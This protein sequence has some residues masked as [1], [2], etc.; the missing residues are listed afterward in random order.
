MHCR[1]TVSK[2]IDTLKFPYAESIPDALREM[3]E[4]PSVRRLRNIGMNCGCE[5]TS[6][7]VFRRPGGYH[8]FEHSLGVA[9]I[10]WRFTDDLKQAAAGL[11]HDIATPVFAHVIDFVKGDYLNQEATESG[12]REC[13][14]ADRALMS[15]LKHGGLDVE[16]VCDYHR[17]PV[18]DNDSPRL[19]ADRL[20]YTLGNILH[21][22]FDTRETV[23]EIYQ[24]LTVAVNEEGDPEISF[25]HANTARKFAGLALRC[26]RLY[27]SPEDR[28]AMQRLAEVIRY[29]LKSGTL[30][31]DSL[32]GTEP[33]VVSR[34][35]EDARTAEAWKAFTGLAAVRLTD[36]P[37]GCVNPRLIPA[38]KRRIDPYVAKQGRVTELFPDFAEELKAFMN[39]SQQVW[40]CEK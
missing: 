7:P 17:Y 18:A 35:R 31:P 15:V 8:R 12:T 38:K 29:A 9:L 11:L 22:G 32:Y 40:I 20:E 34:L 26:S 1:G 13:I 28:Y 36:R 33:E 10:V 39:E 30:T 4:T 27:V 37:E 5:Y 25:T 16:D 3:A 6:F 14:E 2:T 19:S 21:F 24:D 23:S